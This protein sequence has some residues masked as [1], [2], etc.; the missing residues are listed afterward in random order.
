MH[1]FD[2]GRD[3]F[4]VDKDIHGMEWTRDKTLELLHAYQERR[5]LWDW[6]ARGYR[7]RTK[8]RR[9][10]QELADML[11]CN[12]LEI[13]K[14]ITNLKCQYS[15]EVHKI[16]NS[17]DVATGPDDIYV[18]KWFAFKA[19]QFLRFGTRRYSKRKKKVDPIKIEEEEY[20]V[21]DIDPESI[22][23]HACDDG[24]NGSATGSVINASL[25]ED[26]EESFLSSIKIGENDRLGLTMK[27]E[28]SIDPNDEEMNAEGHNDEDWKIKEDYV[29][30]GESIAAQ[31]AQVPDSY[32]RSVAKLRIN[33]ILFEAEIGVYA[34]TRS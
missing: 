2:V 19:M 11:N 24:T 32:S 12:T 9:A 15:R 20:I 31:L 30:F 29:K 7:D 6:G 25:C 16:Q 21:S 14:K 1:G 3:Y 28:R 23:F 22:A 13:E 8:R 26:A 18:S 33:Q 17:R 27:D 5:M 34:Q 4:G 10:I